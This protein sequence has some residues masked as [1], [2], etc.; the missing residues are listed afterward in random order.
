ME[1]LKR[2]ISFVPPVVVRSTKPPNGFFA[3]FLLGGGREYA[4]MRLST[5]D[6]RLSAC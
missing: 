3:V 1:R 2:Y 5:K 6:A 4:R